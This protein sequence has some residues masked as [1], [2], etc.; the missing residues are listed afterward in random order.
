[1]TKQVLI[2][3]SSPASEKSVSN[4]IVDHFQKQL[5]EKNKEFEF[6]IRDL[7][8]TPPPIYNTE[9]LNAF[10]TPAE[11][12]TGKQR[13]ISAVSLNYIEEIKTADIIVIASP[14]HNFGVTSLLKAYIDQICRVGLTFKYSDQGPEG[15]IKNKT[16]ILVTTAGGDFTGE[17]EKHKDFQTP[18]LKHILNFIGITDIHVVPAHGMGLGEEIAQQSKDNAK[19]KL[20]E[21]SKAVL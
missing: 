7:A 5:T 20:N 11:H 17:S 2:I 14:M 13:N 10:Y 1:M 4:E 18:Y 19:K 8:T 9:T 16:A 21:L 15:F 12:L 6:V 3:K